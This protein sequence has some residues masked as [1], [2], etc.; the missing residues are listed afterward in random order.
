MVLALSFS[1]MEGMKKKNL[2]QQTKV[3][4]DDFYEVYSLLFY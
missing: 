4:K 2:D 3:A 1:M